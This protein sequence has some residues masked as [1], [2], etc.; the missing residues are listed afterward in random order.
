MKLFDL[1]D[2]FFKPLWLRIAIVLVAGAW[3]IFEFMSGAM[4][5]GTL[6]VGI[7]AIAFHGFFIAFNPRGPGSKGEEQE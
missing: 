6:F 7:A 4:F 2:P 5:W 1:N 3:G